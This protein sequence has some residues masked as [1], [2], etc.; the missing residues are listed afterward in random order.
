MTSEILG[1]IISHVGLTEDEATRV[2]EAIVDGTLT[3]TQ[4][5]AILAALRTKRESVDEITAFARVMRGRAVRV[6]TRRHPLLDTCGTGGDGAGTMNISTCAAFVVSAAG[7]A[8]AKHG[9][10]AVSSKCG[11]ADVL[12]A[13]GVQLQLSAE[14]IGQC[15]D[16]IGV[17]FMYAPQHH[18]AMRNVVQVRRELG[19]RTVFN[20]VGPLSNPA[21]TDRQLIGVFDPD[22][23]PVVAEALGRLGCTRAMVVHGMEGLDEISTAGPTTISHL[24][25]GRVTT[26][27]RIPGELFVQPASAADLAV[28]GTIEGNAQVLL[29][30]LNGSHGAHR[31]IVC[32]NAAAGLMLGGLAEG[33]RDG[34][35]IAAR[36]IDSGRARAVLNNLVMFTQRCVDDER[37]V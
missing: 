10:R 20:I 14:Q 27:V 7:L 5:G 22:L 11:S 15:I 33:W 8:V 36:M 4:V 19:V 18:P 13:L 29:D 1:R 3:H 31:D 34:V 25:H 32:V 26:E 17:G 21:G 6:T 35:A 37:T 9:N 30:V 12:E 2:I 23:C 28:G 24:Q 16:E